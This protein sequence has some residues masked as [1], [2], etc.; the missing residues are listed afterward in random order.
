M[1]KVAKDQHHNPRRPW[2]LYVGHD[3]G[4]YLTEKGVKI[5]IRDKKII[6]LIP[7]HLQTTTTIYADLPTA[8]EMNRMLQLSTT[9]QSS[10]QLTVMEEL[11]KPSSLH[12]RRNAGV[13]S[14]TE[15]ILGTT[16]S[17]PE[18]GP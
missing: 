8:Q 2:E 13:G 9:I 5:Q 7:R 3:D 17:R 16:T 1:L 6:N 4:E 11:C 12:E 15:K 14:G 18:E 10:A